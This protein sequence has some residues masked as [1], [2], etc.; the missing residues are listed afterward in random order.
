M[1][2]ILAILFLAFG[3]ELIAQTG[4]ADNARRMRDRQQLRQAQRY[5]SANQHDAAIRLLRDLYG[6][7]AGNVQYYQ[8]LLE[9]LLQLSRLDEARELIRDQ[10]DSDPG[11]PR[12]EIDLGSVMV[13]GDDREGALQRWAEV[14]DAHG[15]N[16]AVYT[17]V[18]SAM[19]YNRL[20]EQAAET[21]RDAYRRHPDQHF[22]LK[23]LG[24][25]YGMRLQYEEA[26]DHYIRYVAEQPRNYQAVI[27]QIL[28]FRLEDEQVS[29]LSARLR[30][31]LDRHDDLPELQIIAAKFYQQNQ[32]FEPALDL[33][34]DLEDGESRGKWLYEFARTVQSD[35]LYG[36]AI[37]AYEEILDRFPDSPYVLQVYL[38]AAESSL[39]YAQANNDQ[40]YAR[41]AI[42]M[43]QQ[44]ADR[45][46]Q[47]ARVAELRLLEGRI[48]RQFFFDLD[49]AMALY[50]AVADDYTGTPV[51]RD[52]ALVEVAR[53]AIMRG[54]LE[55][56]EAA[57]SEVVSPE[58][59]PA[60]AYLH[61]R[62]AYYRN[63]PDSARAHLDQVIQLEG[64]G[65]EYTNDAL[66]LQVLLGFSGSAPEA[67][68]H[69]AAAEWLLEQ[70]KIPQALNELQLAID[71]APP[72][73][74]RI[75]LHH[76]AARLSA[77]LERYEDAI[78]HCEEAL[79]DPQLALYADETLYILAGIVDHRLN[80]R[81]RAFRLYDRLLAEFP[82]SPFVDNARRRLKT[83]RDQHPDIVQ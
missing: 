17:L 7:N 59:L 47:H 52:E 77:D 30:D 57:L 48:H 69:Y 9:S 13:K 83:L 21:Y 55:R 63:D 76:E 18:A 62:I 38:G 67:A 72:A 51:V 16:V 23:T 81:A 32:R 64:L 33:Y 15:D 45:Y 70:Q 61:A 6:R 44:V 14:I 65:G 20:F 58:Y 40:A 50:E 29:A 22:L 73:G 31:A 71:S 79:S 26:L 34:R 25:F 41:R 66:R 74:F 80:D 8:E 78:A 19:S 5:Q 60:A 42:D 43:I 49:R 53:T 1:R 10:Q 27:R 54:S 3:G 35:S 75:R 82:D 56:A 37:Q 46:P 28:A 11:N 2:I 39:A 4:G 24:D 68:R 36:L 12:Y